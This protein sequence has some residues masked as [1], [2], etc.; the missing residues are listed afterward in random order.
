MAHKW[1]KTSPRTRVCFTCGRRERWT[2]GGWR[3][4]G[5]CAGIGGGCSAQPEPPPLALPP[6][7][8]FVV[9]VGYREPTDQP[10][11]P[12]PAENWDLLRPWLAALRQEDSDDA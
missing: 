2:F 12:P 8:L 11:P 3:V 5:A 4:D 7:V 6:D 9:R 10:P 1:Q